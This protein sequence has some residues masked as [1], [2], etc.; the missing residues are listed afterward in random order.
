M[1][2]SIEKQ[3]S[4]YLEKHQ[5]AKVNRLIDDLVRNREY[6]LLVETVTDLLDLR[7]FNVLNWIERDMKRHPLLPTYRRLLDL[8]IKSDK[9]DYITYSQRAAL[10]YELD[11]FE[12]SAKDFSAYVRGLRDSLSLRKIKH[13]EILAASLNHW[14]EASIHAHRFKEANLAIQ[15][16]KSLEPKSGWHV[17][18]EGLWFHEQGELD[19]ARHKYEEAQR[20]GDT[21]FVDIYIKIL[22]N[23]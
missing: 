21:M 2:T 3:L 16:A 20:M 12:Q 10:L 13:R 4:D 23:R 1:K 8:L 5:W 19:V 22:G 11:E 18:T 17:E 14:A 6:T 15:E 9:A 7:V